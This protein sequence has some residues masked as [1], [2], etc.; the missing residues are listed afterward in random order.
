M[1]KE[2]NLVIKSAVREVAGDI[3]ISDEFFDALNK[4]V[5]EL[6]KEAVKRAEANGRKTLR[7][8]DV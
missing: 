2:A 5:A 1:A 4:K 7:G 8:A 3:R 6:V